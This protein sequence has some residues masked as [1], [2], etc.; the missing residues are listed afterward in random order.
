M[1]KLAITPAGGVWFSCGPIRG[2][3]PPGFGRFRGSHAPGC[4]IRIGT[5]VAGPNGISS[6]PF[7]VDGAVERQEQRRRGK[8]GD[9]EEHCIGV[10]SAEGQRSNLP[11]ARR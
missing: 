3:S 5:A 9:G 4:G 1:I 11:K 2:V 6:A 7:P 8:S 10:K